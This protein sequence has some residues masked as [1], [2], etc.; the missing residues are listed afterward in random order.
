MLTMLP[1]PIS[2]RATYPPEPKGMMSSL[3][4]ELSGIALRQENGEKRSNSIASLDCIEGVFCRSHVLF[5]QE[6]IEPQQIVFRLRREANLVA[7][8]WIRPR[9]A[10]P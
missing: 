1:G 4:N 6:V 3:R 7:L 9:V 10:S 8:H 5:Q 2:N